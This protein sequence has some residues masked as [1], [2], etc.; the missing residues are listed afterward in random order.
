MEDRQEQEQRFEEARL[1]WIQRH[2]RSSTK[3][4]RRRLEQGQKEKD[5]LFLKEIW[6]PVFGRLDDLHPQYE[7]Q[8]EKGAPVFLDFAWLQGNQYFHI[9]VKEFETYARQTEEERN[10]EM[11]FNAYMTICGYRMLPIAYDALVEDPAE[12]RSL[13][14]SFKEKADQGKFGLFPS[15]RRVYRYIELPQGWRRR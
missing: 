6:W 12:I 8:D 14:A 13:M 4:R 3:E 2:L 5:M 1:A 7:V 15:E 9:A 11:M 10:R